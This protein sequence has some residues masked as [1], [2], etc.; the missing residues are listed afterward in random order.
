MDRR[1]DAKSRVTP[2]EDSRIGY[3][4]TQEET[5]AVSRGQP[6]ATSSYSGKFLVRM[7]S[8]LHEQ[9]ARAAERDE[10]SLNR[11]VTE[12]LATSLRPDATAPASPETS[13]NSKAPAEPAAPSPR[14]SSSTVRVALA[15]NLVIVVA[16]GLVAVIL[17]V[18]ALQRGI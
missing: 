8:E 11:F 13:R 6:K 7:P 9:L 10:V 5:T 16:A 4:G 14:L 2:G 12:A 17:L 1:G 3:V 18:L 15:T